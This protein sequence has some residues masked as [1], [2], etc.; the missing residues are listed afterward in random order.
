M[1][2]FGRYYLPPAGEVILE[3]HDKRI[4]GHKR[5]RYLVEYQGLG[6]EYQD[7]PPLSGERAPSAPVGEPPVAGPS[8][9]LPSTMANEM[10]VP[11]LNP[12]GH[13]DST[14]RIWAKAKEN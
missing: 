14:R 7:H 13:F 6:N 8:S 2:V 1:D 12:C 9:T 3:Q 5:D 10:R 11:D 4:M